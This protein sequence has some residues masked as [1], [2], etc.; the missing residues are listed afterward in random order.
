MQWFLNLKLTYKLAVLFA[1]VLLLVITN[2]A[3]SLIELRTINHQ[4]S[5]IIT[6]SMPQIY[7]LGAMQSNLN[8]MRIAELRHVV[9]HSP[10][11]MAAVKEGHEEAIG[12]YRYNDSLYATLIT[13]S[14]ESEQHQR[15][16]TL[17]YEYEQLSRN[18]VIL[19][20]QNR[21]DEALELI[22]GKTRTL[23]GEASQIIIDLSAATIERGRE[24]GIT[25]DRF[26]QRALRGGIVAAVV[27]TFIILTLALIVG[28]SVSRR[29]KHLTNA[30][31]SIAAG[32][33]D[34]KVNVDSTDELGRLGNSF[35]IM[36]ENL[37]V[38]FDHANKKNQEALYAAEKAEE[39]RMV[40]LLQEQYLSESVTK[41]LG[42]VRLV[43]EGDLTQ[44]IGYHQKLYKGE[45]D[46]IARLYEGL[47]QTFQRIREI[48]LQIQSSANKTAESVQTINIDLEHLS[49]STQEQ[50]VQTTQIAESVEKF[51]QTLRETVDRIVHASKE[52]N[53]AQL[54]VTGGHTAI[55]T[56]IEGI[57][58]LSNLV[59]TTAEMTEKLGAS[60][61]QIG[62][63]VEVI[64]EIAD[65]TNLLALNA[66]IE[67]ARAGEQGR[68]FAVVADEVRKLAERTQKATKEIAQTVQ[69]I[70]YVTQITMQAMNQGK[71]MV[72][73]NEHAVHQTNEAFSTIAK[74]TQ[75]FADIMEHLL[76]MSEKQNVTSSEM[77]KNIQSISQV[78]GDSAERVHSIA[79]NAEGVQQETENLLKTIKQFHINRQISRKSHLP[80]VLPDHTQ[81]NIVTIS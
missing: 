3:L 11:I 19:S 63:V 50:S 76:R 72:Q 15:L 37:R 38:A 61:E 67:A 39:A 71:Q 41:M 78:F 1:V 27:I 23:R 34:I 5:Q 60:S 36:T 21:K 24:E 75:H 2:N 26:V 80:L 73:T 44:S 48:L 62:A 66:A 52:A 12:K 70:Q 58:N 81:S 32:N 64:D 53:S 17:F 56:M 54:A 46:D 77:A 68:G 10:E 65:Q 16:R 69:Q 4:A 79:T 57:N 14:N 43:A 30:T 8:E 59:L 31:Q 7:Y 35:N 45:S 55:N 40:L 47:N 25:T 29:L 49:A 22:K 9:E 13:L 33:T 18:V 6:R 42:V 74:R 20:S 51:T 28:R